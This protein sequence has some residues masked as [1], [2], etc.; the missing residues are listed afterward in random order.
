VVAGEFLYRFRAGSRLEENLQ[1]L[2]GFFT[3]PYVVVVPVLSGYRRPLRRH[4]LDPEVVRNANPTND[5]SI[6]A[7]AMEMGADLISF[8]RHFE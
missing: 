3:S 7:H 6:A 1:G 2:K 5:I 8:Y 4:R